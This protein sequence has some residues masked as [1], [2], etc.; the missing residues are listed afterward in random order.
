MSAEL[1]CLF[2]KNFELLRVNQ[3]WCRFFGFAEEIAI[4]RS[5][6]EFVPE[7]HHDEVTTGLLALGQDLRA[8]SHQ[9]AVGFASHTIGWVQWTYRAI[10]DQLGEVVAYEAVGHLA[11][12]EGRSELFR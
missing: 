3:T 1:V 2:G 5:F 4:G 10:V 9:H 8:A 11:N 6:F 12:E 7:K